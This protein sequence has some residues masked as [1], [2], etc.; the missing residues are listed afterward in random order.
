MACAHVNNKEGDMMR[1]IV[2]TLALL[3]LLT[4]CARHASNEPYASPV[5]DDKA[6]CEARGGTWQVATGSCIMN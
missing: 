6:S 4:G 5:T 1:V 3:T 2:P